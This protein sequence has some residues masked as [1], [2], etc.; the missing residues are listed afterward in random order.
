MV[1]SD[2]EYLEPTA[3]VDVIEGSAGAFVGVWAW[4]EGHFTR[5]WGN[6]TTFAKVFPNGSSIAIG[7]GGAL[8]IAYTPPPSK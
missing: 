7:I 4:A 2:L 8:A 6:T 5:T 1:I 3:D